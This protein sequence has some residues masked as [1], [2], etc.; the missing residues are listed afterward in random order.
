MP[1]AGRNPLNRFDER[2][3]P[4]VDVLERP[5]AER[6]QHETLESIMDWLAGPARLGVGALKREWLE[7]I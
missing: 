1:T 3:F 6:P 2:L 4:T 5:A 7:K